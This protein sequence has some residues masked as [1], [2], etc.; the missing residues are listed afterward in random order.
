MSLVSWIR[1]A[2]GLTDRESWRIVADTGNYAGKSVTVDSALQLSTVWACTRLIAE[3]VGTLPLVLYSDDGKGRSPATGDDL[4]TLLHDAPNADMT[5]VEFWEAVAVCLALWGNAYAEKR[6]LG[7][8]VVA[9]HPLSPA[10]VQPFRRDGKLVYRYLD[11]KGETREIAEDAMFHVR[12]FGSMGEVGLSVISYARHSLGIAMAADESLGRLHANG[13]RPSGV[14][15]MEGTLTPEQRAM[16]RA[17]IVGPMSGVDNAGKIFLL[18]AG[19]RFE[20]ISISPVDAQMLETRAFAVEDI[21]RWFRVPPH[22]VGHTTKST[23]W[24]T[25]L[26]QQ[27]I[28]FLQFALRPYLTRIE[29][30]I[31][32]SLIPAE[33]RK[34]LKAEFSVEGLLRGDSAAR[35]SFYAVMVQNGIYSRNEVRALENRAPKAGADE[36]TVQA[37]NVPL[38]AP[39]PNPTP[40]PAPADDED[41][42]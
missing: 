2:I 8:R 26:E 7:R 33:Q 21:C 31:R 36:L 37:Q 18:E 5:A 35:A 19:M 22:M 28:A 27:Q 25:G 41:A 32:R 42:A 9:L 4:Y 16:A 17:N 29:Q 24:G 20:P 3:T 38:G 12:G 6:T 34:R 14:L 11:P 30:A 23:S 39:A 13:V 40:T 1:R 15:Q 10:R